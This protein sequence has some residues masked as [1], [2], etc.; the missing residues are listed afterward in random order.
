M[1]HY[2]LIHDFYCQNWCYAVYDSN[3]GSVQVES[4][5][6]GPVGCLKE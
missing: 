5:G 2:G 6:V 4:D 3:Y 1:L